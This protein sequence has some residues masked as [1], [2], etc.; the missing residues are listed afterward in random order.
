MDQEVVLLELQSVV[1]MFF[2]HSDVAQVQS[3]ILK[4]IDLH[5]HFPEGA[6]GKDGPSGGIALAVAIISCLSGRFGLRTCM[7]GHV[8]GR[9]APTPP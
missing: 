5:I 2:S 3:S 6:V 9:P 4:E 1:H 8:T 7:K